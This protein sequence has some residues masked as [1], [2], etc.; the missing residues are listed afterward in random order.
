LKG[1]ISGGLFPVRAVLLGRCIGAA[2]LLAVRSCLGIRF[3][4]DLTDEI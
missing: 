4:K 1:L 3:K 2:G